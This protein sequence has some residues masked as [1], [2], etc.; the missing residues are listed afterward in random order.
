[1]VLEFWAIKVESC[2]L[3]YKS[4]LFS[5]FHLW[6]LITPEPLVCNFL[7]KTYWEAS[8]INANTLV[9]LI[10]MGYGINVGGWIFQKY[11]KCRVWNYRRGV[12]NLWKVNICRRVN[13]PKILIIIGSNIRVGAPFFIIFMHA[14]CW[15]W[16]GKWFAKTRN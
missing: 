12:E 11:N 7:V 1:M 15:I 4:G 2:H 10:N 5:Y 14:K 6:W 9:S 16:K 13:S 3:P 8:Y